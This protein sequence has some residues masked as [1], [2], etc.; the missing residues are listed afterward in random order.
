M[1]TGRLD[2]LIHSLSSVEEKIIQAIQDVI[3]NNAHWIVELN[4]EIQLY[5]K[6]EN[7]KGVELAS[8]APYSRA[9]IAIKREKGQPTGRVTLRDTGDFH[10]SFFIEYTSDSFEITASDHKTYD[11]VKEY[12]EDIFGLTD[13]HFK[14]IAEHYVKPELIKLFKKL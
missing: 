12:G 3:K 7:R 11:L 10:R 5:E 8:Y 9:T 13:E 6:G 2:S 1:A 14:D 4:S